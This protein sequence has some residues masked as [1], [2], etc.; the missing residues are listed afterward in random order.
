MLACTAIP[1]GALSPTK[2]LMRSVGIANTTHRGLH[3]SGDQRQSR[4]L[5]H[6]SLLARESRSKVTL[7]AFL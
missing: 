4:L 5:R 3:A 2:E 1:D 7:K 6:K